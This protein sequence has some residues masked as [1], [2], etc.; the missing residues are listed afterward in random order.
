M[1]GTVLVFFMQAGFA[2]LTVGCVRYKNTKNILLKNVMDASIGAVCWWLTGY[3]FAMGEGSG[4]VGTTNFAADGLWEGNLEAGWLFQW[5]FA[6]TAATIVS[7]AVAERISFLAYC[8][9][10]VLLT[11][12]VYPAV[13]HWGWGEGFASAWREENLLF[14]CGMIDFAGSGVVHLTG[15]V[16]SLVGCI[17]VGPRTGRFAQVGGD[18]VDMTGQSVQMQTLGTLILWVGWYGFNGA[19]T[20]YIAGFSGV[21]A[22]TMMTTTIAAASGCLT[23]CVI[24]KMHKHY[25]DIEFANNGVLA[26]L[27]AITSGCSTVT[28]EG[29][30]II[31]VLGAALYYLAAEAMDKAK[32]DDVVR[33]V[34]VHMVNGIWGVIA[35]G[36]FADPMYYGAAYYAARADDC[37][38]LFYGGSGASLGAGIVFIG[39]VMAWVG[40]W[41]GALFLGLKFAG[42]LRVTEEQEE[43][44]MDISKHGGLDGSMSGG[45]IGMAGVGPG[46][47]AQA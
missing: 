21:A 39:A 27:V 33:A 23:C 2:M 37:A 38:G 43:V 31:G 16:A 15:G 47:T 13:V 18:T 19:S 10:A 12:F 25:I 35:A 6:A 32:I 41:M 36:L 17:L 22:H 45:V 8:G 3:G 14:G 9:Y 29:A 30:F 26:G 28:H 7:G 42:M 20:L 34:P 40:A 5:A 46:G 11:G 44:G 24:G 1:F 4:I